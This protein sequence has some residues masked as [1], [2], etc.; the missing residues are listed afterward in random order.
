MCHN[1]LQIVS[2]TA[3]IVQ[4][5]DKFQKYVVQMLQTHFALQ[6]LH[7]FLCTVFQLHAVDSFDPNKCVQ[8]VARQEANLW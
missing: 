4:H 2:I 3:N 1:M 6:L 7:C 5:T 8:D